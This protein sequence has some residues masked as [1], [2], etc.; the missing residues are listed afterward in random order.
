M[1]SGL[2]ALA[3]CTLLALWLSGAR[4][5]AWLA[6]YASFV[7]FVTLDLADG[8][9]TAEA[10]GSGVAQTKM[11]VRLAATGLALLLTLPRRSASTAA[12]TPT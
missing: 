9:Q 3:L 1:T 12:P 8:A 4:S 5:L 10:L 11:F 6:Y 2:L 7:P